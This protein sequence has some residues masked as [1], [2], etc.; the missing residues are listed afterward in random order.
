M[1]GEKVGLEVER[2]E[3]VKDGNS[4]GITDGYS[5]KMKEVGRVKEGNSEGE[6]QKEQSLEFVMKEMKWMLKATPLATAKELKSAPLWWVTLKEFQLG[7]GMNDSISV[8]FGLGLSESENAGSNDGKI[9]VVGEFD[10]NSVEEY[11]EIYVG[12]IVGLV[13]GSTV[14]GKKVGS[15]LG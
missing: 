12:R 2:I 9:V 3:G 11:E 5:D 7:D 10:G 13:V 1:V 8:G 14:E 6:L 4:D 15:S